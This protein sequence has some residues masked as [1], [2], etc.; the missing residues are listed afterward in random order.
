MRLH[1]RLCP[2][3]GGPQG[4][5]GPHRGLQRALPQLQV[6]RPLAGHR[7]ALRGVRRPKDLRQVPQM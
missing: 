5:G 1:G 6:E 2:R 7:E 4:E 3:V